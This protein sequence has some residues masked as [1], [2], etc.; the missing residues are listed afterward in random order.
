MKHTTY[1]ELLGKIK[2][3]IIAVILF[4]GVQGLFAYSNTVGP[5]TLNSTVDGPI[6]IGNVAQTKSGKL[7]IN[8]LP[9]LQYNFLV[10]KPNTGA[11][12]SGVALF[13]GGV[14]TG[15]AYFE[16]DVV[17]GGVVPTT[18]SVYGDIKVL[19]TGSELINAQL[20]HNESTPQ[21]VCSDAQGTLIF[22]TPLISTN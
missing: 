20:R 10:T 4:F 15:S 22:C 2:V 13:T 18:V 3:L 21:P 5:A 16:K 9:P 11:R 1:K 17:V 6:N 19:G 12:A 7:G 14:R 8:G